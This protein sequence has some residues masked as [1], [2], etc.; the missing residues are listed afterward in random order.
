MGWDFS[1]AWNTKA[2]CYKAIEGDCSSGTCKI[3]AS[4]P[5]K[6]GLWLA[7]ESGEGVRYTVLALIERNSS[8]QYY[9]FKLM[10]EG[11]GFFFFHIPVKIWDLVKDAPPLGDYSAA[12]RA[13]V[14]PS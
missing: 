14:V 11:M 5:T 13:K 1:P 2:K 6:D 9:G 4:A 12:W 8:K 3:L 10:D 7:I